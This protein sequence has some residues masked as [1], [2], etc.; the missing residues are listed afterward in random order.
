MY[1]ITVHK[2]TIEIADVREHIFINKDE[3]NEFIR[4]LNIVAFDLMHEVE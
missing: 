2:N 4:D 3:L 1:D